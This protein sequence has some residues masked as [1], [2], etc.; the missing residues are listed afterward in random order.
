MQLQDDRSQNRRGPIIEPEHQ[1][2]RYGGEL[3]AEEL[4][5]VEMKAEEL[6]AVIARRLAEN[7]SERSRTGRGSEGRG[8]ES[9]DVPRMAGITRKTF[10]D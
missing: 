8:V 2:V 4:E 1:D 3:K 9:R 6:Q 10:P 7:H 5:T